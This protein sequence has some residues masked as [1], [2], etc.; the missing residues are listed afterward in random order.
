MAVCDTVLRK[1]GTDGGGV[2]VGKIIGFLLGLF[3]GLC[4]EHGSH[5]PVIFQRRHHHIKAF[6]VQLLYIVL[7]LAGR[8]TAHGHAAIFGDIALGQGQIEG[9]R[10]VPC[11]VTLNPSVQLKEVA[12]LI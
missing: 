5:T 11:V 8:K 12:H 9:L 4:G 3:P 7:Q 1:G 10:R 6:A 2:N